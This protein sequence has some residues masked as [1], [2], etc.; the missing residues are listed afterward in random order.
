MIVTSLLGFLDCSLEY[1]GMVEAFK[2]A[3]MITVSHEDVEGL[4]TD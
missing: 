3:K 2:L 4:V 1:R